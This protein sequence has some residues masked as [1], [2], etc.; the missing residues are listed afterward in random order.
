[1]NLIG[2]A[3]ER[4]ESNP[5]YVEFK[6]KNPVLDDEKFQWK[7]WMV[8]KYF[9]DNVVINLIKIVIGVALLI[10]SGSTIL[11]Q[12]KS[13]GL[14]SFMMVTCLSLGII[15]TMTGL[16]FV[17]SN[18]NCKKKF[19]DFLWDEDAENTED[20]LATKIIQFYSRNHL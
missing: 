4:T 7:C 17:I 12:I 6:N 1:M 14:K 11:L 9:H 20:S 16:I 2:T 18:H 10:V 19:Q 3:L 5:L 15:M 13:K 8:K